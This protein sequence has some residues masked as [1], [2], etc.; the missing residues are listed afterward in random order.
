MPQNIAIA[1]VGRLDC[2][3]E[4]YQWEFA[5]TQAAEI[6]AH[7]ER[8]R[9]DRP[10][11]YNGRVLL[12]HKW[13]IARG[14]HAGILRT[15]HFETDFKNFIAWRDFGFADARVRNCFSMAALRGSD[16]AYVLGI[17][18]EHTSNAG[19]IYFPAGTPDPDDIVDGRLD[20]AGSALRELAEETGLDAGQMQVAADWSI[21]DAGP[22][23]GCMKLVQADVDAATLQARI[24]AFLARQKQP[25]LSAV[26]L[27]R[28]RADIVPA[29]MSDF[30]IAWLEA[31][32][33]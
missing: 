12:M 6:D 21:V 20:L 27:V 16:G 7:W 2:H 29:R 1:P 28:T 11:L 26:H 30:M 10:A 5:R 24:G 32:L 22:R 23:L 3:V 31:H 13:E 18:G 9:A 25:E 14:D 4:N 33:P 15:R 8:L 17:M 19:M